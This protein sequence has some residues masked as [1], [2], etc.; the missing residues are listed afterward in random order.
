MVKFVLESRTALGRTGLISKWGT[1]DVDHRTPSCL[2]YTRAGHIPHLTWEVATKWLRHIQQPIFQ[3]TLP[4]FLEMLPVIEK[5]GK[6]VAAFCSMPNDAPTHISTFD[7]LSKLESGFNDTKSIAIWT[8]SGKRSVDVKLLHG[9]VTSCHASTFET[10]FDYDTPRNCSNKRLTKAV[11]R[12][13][14]FHRALFDDYPPVQSAAFISL[15]GGS[16]KYHRERF[17]REL[18]NVKEASGFAISLSQYSRYKPQELSKSERKAVKRKAND[19]AEE[20]FSPVERGAGDEARSRTEKVETSNGPDVAVEGGSSDER[21][22]SSL[23]AFNAEEIEEI[24]ESIYPHIPSSCL[25]LVNGAFSPT[26]ILSLIKLGIDLFDSSYPVLLA[27]QG[28]SFRLSEDFPKDNTFSIFDYNN[29]ELFADDFTRPY[30]NCDCYTCSHY[31][32]GYLQ[33]LRN[34]KE[35]L[36]PI[37]L[38]IHNLQEF[39]RMFELIRKHI[40]EQRSL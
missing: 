12:S 14:E 30:G 38:V 4:S 28:M 22:N 29:A 36:G 18:G 13:V 27:E 2:I 11:N 32:K 23:E 1:Q 6:G 20:R 5:F 17:A 33:H 9:L 39:E 15:G 25:R 8:R 35:L 31:T 26:E 7:P 24:L 37:L 40:A 16:S 34:T 21:R 3:L 19:T 10:L